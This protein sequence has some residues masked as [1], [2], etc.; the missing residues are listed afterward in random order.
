MLINKL[1]EV[2]NLQGVGSDGGFVVVSSVSSFFSSTNGS[3]F[4]L[5]PSTFFAV[6]DSIKDNF[7]FERTG[8]AEALLI[9]A[10]S[11]LV[12]DL[13]DESEYAD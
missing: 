13:T 11:L 6:G 9:I 8:L 10:S 7:R 3:E 12:F 5:S 2:L 1:T 4:S